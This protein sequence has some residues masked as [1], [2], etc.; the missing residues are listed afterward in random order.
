M[1]N[2]RKSTSRRSTARKSPSRR[3]TARKSTASGEP[4]ALRRLNKSL[5]SA[6]DALKALRKDVG[7]DVS[8]GTRGLYGDLQ[9]FVKDARRD[10]TKLGRALG[11]DVQKLQQR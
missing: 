10:S 2:A 5:D 6:Q 9:K 11:R 3:S 7:R 1:A 4:A 8:T